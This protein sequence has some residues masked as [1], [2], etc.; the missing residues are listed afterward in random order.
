M[1]RLV[2]H[3]GATLRY[4]VEG[5][6]QYTRTEFLAKSDWGHSPVDYAGLVA[7][8]ARA[9]QLCLFHHDPSHCDDDLDAIAQ[10]A[11]AEAAP[12]SVAVL[13]ATEGLTVTL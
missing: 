5:D 6:A 8:K 12:A 9:R 4:R 10:W 7:T 2:P 1:S 11:R 3:P 13:A